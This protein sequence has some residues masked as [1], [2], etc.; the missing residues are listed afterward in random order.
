MSD[1]EWGD[2]EPKEEVKYEM[3]E[4][5][6][7]YYPENGQEELTL[8]KYDLVYVFKKEAGAKYWEGEN[9][10]I[11]GKFPSAHVRLVKDMPKGGDQ[12]TQQFYFGKSRNN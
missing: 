5:I 10:G 8:E 11:Y 12:K 7:D 1:D 3:A 6:E 2:D 4:V 9:K